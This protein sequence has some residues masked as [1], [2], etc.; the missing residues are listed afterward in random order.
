MSCNCNKKSAAQKYNFTAQPLTA[1]P[2][3]LNMGSSA[4]LPSGLALV[5]RGNNIAVRKTGLYRVTAQ[6]IAAVTTAGTV[7][8]QL[9]YGGVPIASTIKSLPAAVDSTEICIDTLLYLVVP[10]GCCCNDV[11]LP[12]DVYAWVS[13]AGAASIASVT[14]NALKEA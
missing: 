2:A 6:L 13:G 9:Y 7:N 11:A 8:A 5:D 3:A 4:G 14:V 12:V 10:D 1:T